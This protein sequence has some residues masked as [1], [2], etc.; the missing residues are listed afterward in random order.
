M[1][2]ITNI[3]AVT[4]RPVLHSKSPFLFNRSFE[5]NGDKAVYTRISAES[6]SHAI[7]LFKDIGLSGMN[8]TS[9][10]KQDILENLDKA[11]P[12]VSAIGAANTVVLDGTLLQGFNTDH[13]GVTSSLKHHGLHLQDSACLVLGAGGAGRAAA[14]GLIQEGAHVI[15]TNRTYEKAE[16][17]AESLGCQ[18]APL[19]SLKSLLDNTEIVVSALTPRINPIEQEWLRSSHV[20][21]DANY[22]FSSLRTLAQKQGCT[23]ISGEDWLLHQA[24]PA[25]KLFTGR[26]ANRKSLVDALSSGF[27][28]KTIYDNISLVG[29]MGCGKTTVG[30]ILAEKLGY[31]FTDIDR[32]IEEREGETIPEIFQLKGEHG[33]RT[34]E[35]SMLPEIYQDKKAV[36]AC[37]GGVVLDPTNRDTI[38]QNSLV[39]WLYASMESSLQRIEPGSRPLLNSRENRKE[40][41]LLF[42]T[43]IPHYARI[44]DLVVSSDCD[45]EK[46][47]E[48]IYEEIHHTLTD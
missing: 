4:G 31:S 19:D 37:G 1:S 24:I 43:R 47:A 14:Y 3:F 48:N 28:Y 8:V 32:M 11:D 46:T 40:L 10:F 18:A 35:K 38:S 12:A 25:Y 5:D 36:F 21:L 30:P 22:P 29:F 13:I 20:I 17:A 2:E 39:V 27:K 34:L 41:E 7:F 26:E 42:R 33:F 44:A 6:A 16:Q 23:T 45:P 15:L 9:P